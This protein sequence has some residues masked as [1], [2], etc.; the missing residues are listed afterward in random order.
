[1]NSNWLPVVAK[2][3]WSGM[4]R[5]SPAILTSMSV[6]GLIGTTVLA[7]KAT[8]KA[9]RLLEEEY[10]KRFNAGLELDD[11]ALDKMD[12]VKLTWRLYLPAVGLG[13]VTIACVVGSNSIHLRRN[14]ALA[15][16][17][18]LT[19]S[20]LK[21]YK[22]KVVETIGENKERKVREDIIQ[23]KL[24]AAPM[25]TREIIITGGGDQLCCDILSERYF[26]SDIEKLRRSEN[27]IVKNL[28]LNGGMSLNEVY[29]EIG[30]GPTKLGSYLGFNTDNPL[31][32]QFTSKLNDVGDP[33][34]VVD[35]ATG[36][37]ED[38]NRTY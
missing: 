1:M 22:A 27:K 12:A 19:E 38:Y 14:A 9:M 20:T 7:V 29:A 3:I 15:G 5:N 6:A 2:P 13:L 21:E 11:C 28:G 17:Y 18:S 33:C 32:F 30:L 25:A 37:I 4:K 16:L 23:D 24:D 8:P 36:P 26:K 10:H 34:L 31:E 35:Y